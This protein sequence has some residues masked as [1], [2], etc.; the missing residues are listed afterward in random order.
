MATEIEIPTSDGRQLAASLALPDGPGPH[1]GVV[2]LHEAF[3][4]NDD[5]RRIAA[6]FADEGY[7]AVVPDLYSAGNR[8]R[9]LSALIMGP[10]QPES[11][12]LIETARRYLADRPE[13]DGR[14]MAV[15]GFCMGGGFALL[16]GARGGVK[17][18]SVNYGAVP[19]QADALQGVCPVVASYGGK[20]RLFRK[21]ADRLEEHLVALGVPHDCKVYEH[22]GHSFMS[23]DNGPAWMTRVPS[24]MH[25]GYSEAE[26]EDA[27][28]RILAFFAE[29]VRP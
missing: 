23:Y 21:Q 12:A 11:L 10:D 25:V 17:A 28:R 4:L 13:V 9:C 26:A 22:V 18:S 2:V 16:V 5:M 6:R 7:A 19:K 29:H 20:D 27:W 14:R 24:P 3:G 15:I 1:A 8:L